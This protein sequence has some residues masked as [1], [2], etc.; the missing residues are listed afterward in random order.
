MVILFSS[1]IF[2]Q[3]TVT[4]TVKESSYNETLIGASVV[5]SG[6]T[7]GTTTD[8]NGNFSIK[9]TA[10]S[11]SLEISYIGYESQKIDVTVKDDETTSIGRVMLNATSIG[12]NG[13]NIIADRAKERET[14]VAVSNVSKATIEQ[15]LGSQDLPMV[16]NNTPSVYATMQGGGAGD[17]RINVRGFDQNNVAIM[18]NGVPIN[19]MENGWVYWSNWD[20]LADVTSSIQMQRGLSAVNLATPS[21]GGTMNIITNPAEMKAG[22]SLKLE[23]GSGNFQKATIS[24][25]TGLLSN[26]FAASV[27]VVRKTGQG[28]IDKTYTDAW[29]YYVGLSYNVNKKHRLELYA[30][31]APQRHGQNLYKQNVAAYS[32]EYAKELGVDNSTLDKF[33]EASSGRLYNENWNTVNPSYTGQ[34]Y[35]DGSFHSRQSK[36]YLHERENYYHKPVVNLNWYAHW[37]EKVSQFTTVYYS[38]GKGGGSGT[39]GSLVWDYTSEPTRIADWNATIARN[40]D[41]E[42]G[43]QGIL[44]N[45]VNNQWTIGAISRVKIEFTDHFRGQVGIDW[46]TAE[47]EHYRTV[48]D[49]LGLQSYHYTG[50]EFD[51]EATYDKKLGGKIDYYNTNTVDW[52]GGFVQL[53]Y[54]NGKLAVDGTFG[55]SGVKYGFTDHFH[56]ADTLADGSPDVNSGERVSKADWI[57]GMQVKGGINYNFTP[58][59]NAFANIGYVT[60]VPIFDNVI[61]D[62]DGSVAPT[63]KNEKFLS[64]ELGVGYNTPD[65]KFKFTGNLYYTNWMDRTFTVSV[66]LDPIT[67]ETGYAYILG[68]D[69]RHMGIEL[70]ANYRPINFIGFGAIASIANWKYLSDVEAQV[71]DDQNN[72]VLEPHVYTK[73]L[74]VGD[75]PQTQVGAWIDIYPTKGM[76]LQL[77]WRLNANHY[78]QFN[79]LTR[80]DSTDRTQAWKTPSYSIF[81][82]HLYYSIPTK[83]KVDV[84]L[85]AHFFNLFD[86][87]YIQDAVDNSQYNG[88]Y[89]DGQFN[90]D[91]NTAEV[92][93]GIPFSYNIGV[94][95][96]IH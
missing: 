76:D 69:Q 40:Q 86:T 89:G 18:I 91:V 75:A 39:Y 70:E 49:L 20:G 1:T 22:G 77:V 59:L 65:N 90:H 51:T 93:L 48:R 52:L 96:A 29:A 25:H 11:Y 7:T 71:K 66:V 19:D 56:T 94:R 13:V 17:A 10:G 58:T 37:G 43:K 35:W 21:V 67:L 26:K 57:G 64:Y 53:E 63:P 41:P 79:P 24:A 83:G 42:S 15:Q 87:Y 3:G 72:I 50:N 81:D 92:Y 16:M 74:K 84:T 78:A 14:P 33:K 45:S 8:I 85:F 62:S 73:D 82:A 44:R 47:I 61:D 5:V 46:R 36:D 32:H 55:Y 68:M 9:L 60:K 2:A 27:S 38:G 80:N 88:N 28:I 95:I 30:M 31:G 54:S 23:Y 34:Q 4:G 6:T 12:L